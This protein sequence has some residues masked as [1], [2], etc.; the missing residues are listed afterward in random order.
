ME[1]LVQRLVHNPHDQDAITYAHSQGQSDPRSYAMLLEKVGTATSDPAYASYWLTQAADVWNTTLGD[2][3]RAA[4][5][6]M[7]AIDRDP[8]QS[9]PADKLAELYREK[10]DTKAL[11][12]L[13]ERRGKALAPLAGQ[14]AEL[15]SVLA[16]IHE[17]L[18]RLWSEAPL[19]QPKKAIDNYRR[20]LELDPRS[21]YAVYA[22]RELLKAAAQWA[23]AVPYFALEQSLVEDPERR[24]ALYLDEAEVRSQAGDTA[25][26]VDALRAARGIEGGADP[27]LKQQ[28]ATLVFDQ[29]QRNDPVAPHDRSEAVQ[30]FVEL[31]EEFQGEH[32]FSYSLCALELDRAHDRAVQLA[33]FYGREL[34]RDAEV[35]SRAADYVAANPGGPLVDEARALAA[36][37]NA[38]AS[39]PGA[40]PEAASSSA[41]SPHAGSRSVSPGPLSAGQ[42]S[43]QPSAASQRAAASEEA[44]RSDG[45]AVKKLLADADEFVRRGKKVEAAK[46]YRDVLAVEPAQV[47]AV[48]FLEGHLRQSRKFQELRD[49]LLAAARDRSASDERRKGWLREAAGLCETQLRDIDAAIESWQLL[50]ALDAEDEN[51]KNQLKR[52]YD[53]SH[54]WDDLAMLLE[55]E[56]ERQG[57]LEARISLEKQLAKLHE[58]KRKDLAGAGECWARISALAPDEAALSTALKYFEKAARPDLGVRVIT[59]NVGALE[60]TSVRASF[61]KK[62]AE[63]NE[64]TGDHA[65]AG[66]AYAEAAALGREARLWEAAEAAFVRAEAFVRAAECLEAR[67]DL[68]SDPRARAALLAKQAGYFDRAGDP[69]QAL[70]R[71]EQASELDPTSDAY[72]AELEERYQAAG[73]PEALVALLLRRAS[74]LR[75][76]AQRIHLRKRAASL[77]R[78]AL[79]DPDGARA[80]LEAVLTDA[81][82]TEALARLADD[83]E[84]RGATLEAVTF[85]GRLGRAEKEPSRRVSVLLREATLVAGG[86]DNPELAIE[87]YEALLRDLDSTNHTALTRIAELSERLG[88][89]ESVADALERLLDLGDEP[90]ARLE[91]GRRLARVYDEELDDPRSAVRLLKL[92][93]ELD[94]EDYAAVLRYARLS[95]RLEDWSALAEALAVLVSVEADSEELSRLARELASVLYERLGRGEDALAAL[96]AAADAGDVFCR[97]EYVR[98]G[99]ALNWKGIVATKLVE[100]SLE[101]P[102]GVERNEA[103]RGAFNRFIEVE[104]FADAARVGVELIRARAWDTELARD[105][106]RVAVV[107]RDVEALEFAHG[108]LVRELSGPPRAE[109]MVRQAE[110]LASAGVEFET[111]IQ[112]GEQALTSVAAADAEELLARLANL[113]PT[114]SVRVDVYER[115]VTRCKAP[116]DR[117]RALARAAQVANEVGLADRAR[118]FLD[119]ALASNVQEDTLNLLVELA[120]DADAREGG[121]RLTA[122]LAQSVAAGGHGARDG[123]KTRAFLLR[124]AA[125]IA[126]QELSD[127]EQAFRWLGDSIVTHVDD[128]SL[129]ALE[130]LALEVGDPTRIERVLDRALEEVF[131]GPLVRKLLGR[132][133]RLRRELLGNLRAASDD[134]KRLHELLPGDQAV[135]DDLLAI[136]RKL[137]DYRGQVA[138]FEGLILRGKDPSVRADLARKVARLWEERL[139]DPR[140]AADAWRRVLRIKAGDGEAQAGLERAKSNMLKKPDPETDGE[141]PPAAEPAEPESSADAGL[142]AADPAV[143]AEEP[144]AAGDEDS[145]EEDTQV[146]EDELEDV[147]ASVDEGSALAAPRVFEPSGP[148]EVEAAESEAAEFGDR[149]TQDANAPPSD[150]AITPPP[151]AVAEPVLLGDRPSV[152]ELPPN[153]FDP[154]PATPRSLSAAPRDVVFAEAS[155]KGAS[156]ED[157][158]TW[159]RDLFASEPDGLETSAGKDDS[160]TSITSPSATAELVDEGTLQSRLVATEVVNEEPHVPVV[161]PRGGEEPPAP[162]APPASSDLG[163]D[164]L[165]TGELPA[166]HA[167]PQHAAPK[168]APQHAAPKS[169]PQHAAPAGSVSAHAF[170]APPAPASAPASAPRRPPLPPPPPAPPTGRRPPPPPPGRRPPPPPPSRVAPPRTAPPPAVDE[171]EILIEEDLILDEDE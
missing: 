13:L 159:T 44:P 98:L 102:A 104:R 92:V 91:L 93:R 144:D 107:L 71:L 39:P 101:A 17:E 162:S 108:V 64:A 154:A 12:A 118:T 125:Q 74:E 46:A 145:E 132:R 169:A 25:G 42:G 138:L 139:R 119:I 168:S 66:E 111:A 69:D 156:L 96:T 133:A 19:A 129:D 57:D 88:R 27:A 148:D 77:Q 155:A 21:A 114:P 48:S 45:H 79:G 26:A 75:E 22:I 10:G 24:L 52:L 115:Q 67:A 137:G 131:D 103:L 158:S 140:E 35:A 14:D 147:V 166:H 149:S 84:E 56:A 53:R 61:Y 40:A 36:R 47:E 34:G 83:A 163:R 135:I 85:L 38:V 134:L 113:A 165:L 136:Y 170:P 5:A 16:G 43:A 29:A 70:A 100:W 15:A 37:F 41:A 164:T 90:P 122:L 2:A 130:A 6:L 59:D 62:L 68:S 81:E 167:A 117:L 151:A 97:E 3:H 58:Q 18:G 8:T 80:S 99:D 109:E 127:T 4:R 20:A 1:A 30:L 54:R 32:G 49:V 82:D 128:V 142:A 86:L 153:T 121:R 51:P 116:Q 73:R 87:R 123:G 28:L 112:H 55:R 60:E 63:L 120:T 124:R 89:W 126:F 78:A 141:L 50:A 72:A 171:D 94:A 157:V 152:V 160:R 161:V 146:D 9:D 31:A 65:G 150:D 110:V 143:P 23:E 95:E 106:E 105:L 76:P 11:V 7:I 33:M